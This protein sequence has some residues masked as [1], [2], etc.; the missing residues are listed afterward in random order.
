MGAIDAKGLD[1]RN[2]AAALTG[3]AGGTG[4][5]GQNASCSGWFFVDDGPPSR[6]GNGGDGSAGNSGNDG[7]AG[8][9]GGVFELHTSVVGSG[10]QID[11]SGGKG[12]DG[13]NGGAGGGGGPGGWLRSGLRRKCVR[14]QWR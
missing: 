4:G 14:W 6:G 5:T 12:G 7:T 11:V 9:P 1:G 10:L 2:A 3:S 8:G 13:G